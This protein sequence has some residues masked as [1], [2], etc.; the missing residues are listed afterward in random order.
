MR[1][2]YQQRFERENILN[3][4][5]FVD[6]VLTLPQDLEREFQQ[7]VEQLEAQQR[8]QDVTLF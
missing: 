7:E 1:K 3:L 5:A 4:L 8:M 6:W 2:L